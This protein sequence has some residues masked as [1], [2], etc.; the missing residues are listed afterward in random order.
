MHAH[1][2][3]FPRCRVSR[4]EPAE[5][6][7][8]KWRPGILSSGTGPLHGAVLGRGALVDP[9]GPPPGDKTAGRCIPAI[10][11]LGCRRLS[12]LLATIGRKCEAKA[13]SIDFA[14]CL[15]SSAY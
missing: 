10:I 13:S 8:K 15:P 4:P 6:V 12:S 11:A 14:P 9:Q 1:V 7:A 2:L 5:H 3:A